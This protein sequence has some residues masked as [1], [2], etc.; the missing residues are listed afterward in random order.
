MDTFAHLPVQHDGRIKPL[1]TYARA[2]LSSLTGKEA[3]GDL[4]AI[5]WLAEAWFDQATAYSRPLFVLPSQ[6]VADALELKVKKGARVPFATLALAIQTHLP[7]LAQLQVLPPEQRTQTQQG[8]LD[9]FVK[10]LDYYALSR[11]VSLVLPVFAVSHTALAATLHVTPTVPFSWVDF[12]PQRDAYVAVANTLPPAQEDDILTMAATLKRMEADRALTEPRLFPSPT[13]TWH[14][15]WSLFEQGASTPESVGQLAV[16]QHMAV[17]YINQQPAA[18]Q[19]ATVAAQQAMRAHASPTRLQ[20]EVLLQRA[21]PFR[22]SALFYALALVALTVWGMAKH[23]VLMRTSMGLAWLGV[24]LHTAGIITRMVLLGRPPVAT[25]YESILFVGLAVVLMGLYLAKRQRTQGLLVATLGGTAL[26]SL[27]ILLVSKGDSMGMLVAVL[28]T[29]FWLATHVV[30]ITFGYAVC[31]VASAYGHLY[32]WQ[33]WQGGEAAAKPLLRTGFVLLVAAIALTSIGTWLGGVW[34]DQS[35]GRFWGWDPKE[36]GALLIVLYLAWLLHGRLAGVL[37][38]VRLAGGMV[39]LNAIVALA[40][41]GV[42]LLGVG[43]HSYGFTSG[44]A[45]G[46]AA[47]CAAE[48]AYASAFLYLLRGTHASR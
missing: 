18:W 21:N 13:S 28:N 47:F 5:D 24:G 14:S 16:W 1:E 36:N 44:L 30:I 31:V 17:A 19:A 12:Q 23:P 29:Q 15:G 4:P 37:N 45:G 2:Q 3:V 43:L 48:I 25:L 22:L 33:R 27:G 34:A 46:L 42:N 32:L 8:V 20:A 41:F 10:S 6:A 11:G 35:W 9:M 39:G 7:L 38:P 26:Q 40:W